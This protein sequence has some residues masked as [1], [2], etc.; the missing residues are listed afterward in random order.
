MKLR[1]FETI[2]NYLVGT[3]C[4]G[5]LACFFLEH[6]SGFRRRIGACM[7]LQKLATLTKGTVNIYHLS[8]SFASP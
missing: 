3:H 5:K 1:G 6:L 7:T 8:S 4:L 2:R